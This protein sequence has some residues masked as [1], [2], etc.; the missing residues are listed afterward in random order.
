MSETAKNK[1][2]S[3]FRA[4]EVFQTKAL[5]KHEINWNSGADYF[6][7]VYGSAETGSPWIGEYFNLSLFD[8]LS[9]YADAAQHKNSEAWYPV[10]ENSN[11]AGQQIVRLMQ[12]KIHDGKTH[13]L[14]VG[15]LRYSFEGGSDLR[16]EYLANSAG[17]TVD[18]NRNAKAALDTQSPLQ[19]ADYKTN[20]VRVARPGLEY[21][22]QRYGMVS[23]RIPDALS[24]KDL[25]LYGR[26]MRSLQDLSSS[27]YAS[28]EYGFGSA[29]TL[30]LSG[31]Y[32]QGEP[33]SDMRGVLASSVS[34][35]IRQDF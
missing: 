35:G 22:G 16:F 2:I 29:S 5:M 8:G 9:L 26:Y 18:D 10:V 25:T 31:L 7:V 33:E 17:W 20:L 30:L 6:G 14:A 21:R 28:I 24:F 19:L 32:N 13:S 12:S 23:L 15:G 3:D 4:E 34:A 1:D 11:V 27:T